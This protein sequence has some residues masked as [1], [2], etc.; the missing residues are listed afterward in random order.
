M[1]RE[2]L[3]LMKRW[4]A[5]VHKSALRGE[6]TKDPVVLSA[7]YAV[8]G[9]R[10]AG[11]EFYAG[12]HSADVIARL[13][14]SDAALLRT[15]IPWGDYDQAPQ[16]YMSGN[17]VRL[18]C[19]W[20]AHLAVKMYRLSDLPS[21][22]KSRRGDWVAGIEETGRP[23]RPRLNRMSTPNYLFAGA[24]GSGKSVALLNAAI[25]L[26]TD[27]RNRLVLLDGK[28]GAGL[29][30]V[31]H[32]QGVVGPVATTLS[33]AKNALLWSIAW[34]RER[35]E[36]GAC[37]AA[38]RA[39]GEQRLIL[40]A[41]EFQEFG[42]QDDDFTALLSSYVARC[43]EADAHAILATQHP[44]QA[45]IK[46]G[47]IKRNLG[48]RVV[49]RVTDSDASKVAVGAETPRADY[50]QDQGDSYVIGQNAVTRCQLCYV[51]QG[52]VDR[53]ET[54]QWEFDDF[55][56]LNGED[57]GSFV[58]GQFSCTMTELGMATVAAHLG[59][60]RDL[61]T[62][63]VNARGFTAGYNRFKRMTAMGSEI[64]DAIEAEGY[65]LRQSAERASTMALVARNDR[66]LV[67]A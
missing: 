31:Q 26:S 11:L 18:D 9:P 29:G 56:E 16:V 12:R 35:Y 43:R 65:E 62:Q 8:D 32:L 39:E 33:D 13:S 44:S 22:P 59:E 20:P 15:L 51:D 2:R 28:W 19:A 5:S 36:N 34:M 66:E 60:G 24:T 47:T 54:G 40:I 57:I 46:D 53:A 14:R 3:A 41:D 63:R 52:D 30:P 45:I 38:G 48:G 25:Q 4:K 49:L 50:L 61:F 23:V 7:F 58:D 37:N 6:L 64:L 55:P 27:P 21:R 67:Y 10:C 42:A 17:R 1:N